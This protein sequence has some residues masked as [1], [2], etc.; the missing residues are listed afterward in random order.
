A[1]SGDYSGHLVAGD[2]R[3]PVAA[4]AVD[5]GRGPLQ[6]ISGEPGR[7]NFNDDVAVVRALKTGEPRRVRLGPLN[8]RHPRRSRGPVR[9]HDRF[10]LT[11]SLS[12]SHRPPRYDVTG[13]LSYP[14]PYGR[15]RMIVF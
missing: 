4:E 6:L 15:T 9:H 5:P 10:H 12:N 13:G 3:R 7:M 1:E 11:A 8:Q 2:R 14:R